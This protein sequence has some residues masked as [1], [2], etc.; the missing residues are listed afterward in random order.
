MKP[1]AADAGK[2]QVSAEPLRAL[3]NALLGAPHLI[4]ELQATREPVE[5]FADNPINVLV[6]EYRAA[7][8]AC[9]GDAKPAQQPAAVDELV[10]RACDVVEGLEST[11]LPG[12]LPA[13]VT[14]LKRAIVALAG[15]AQ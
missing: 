6:A 9:K 14:K 1:T 11:P 7:L 10:K 8:A 15:G 13:R 3:L 2:L 5:L 12:A 4:R